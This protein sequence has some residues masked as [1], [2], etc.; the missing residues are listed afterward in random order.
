ME[1]LQKPI[2]LSIAG[3]DPSGGAG[4]LADIKTFESIGVYGMGV[5]TS[6]TLQ[7][8]NS[9][10]Y[11]RWRHPSVIRSEVE[12]ILQN[13]FV[14]VAKIGIVRHTEML[15][16]I[17]SVLK[18]RNIRII[19]DPVLK[20][21]TKKT[22]F[23]KASI[24]FVKSCLPDLYAL[25]ANFEEAVVISGKP[26]IEEAGKDL[27]KYTNVIIKGGHLSDE[28]EGTDY[29]FQQ[30]SAKVIKIKKQST[31]DI[32]PKHGSGCVHSSA[33]A[34]FL[35]QGFDLEQAAIRAKLYTEHFLASS[36]TLLGF[37]STHDVL[38]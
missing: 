17:V 19:W 31:W 9:L 35:A 12:F 38:A 11:I 30:Y 7:S 28:E 6:Y 4:I 24:P 26:T 2:V 23:T 14:S 29:L 33:L 10:E 21:S 13:D 15:S 18:K 32:Y 20:S 22:I 3:F 34:A 25:T 36:K 37:H 1:K 5:L 27:S 16:D 8:E